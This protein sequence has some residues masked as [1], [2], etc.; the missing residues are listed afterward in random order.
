MSNYFQILSCTSD[1]STCCNDY[2]LVKILSIIKTI[3]VMFQII[4]P[5]LLIVMAVV[6]LIKLVLHPDDK[7]LS[8]GLINK[9]IAALICFILPFIVDLTLSI[10]PDSFQLSGCWK[11]ADQTASTI[12]SNTSTNTKKSGNTKGSTDKVQV[13][14]LIDRDYQTLTLS[15]SSNN[16]SNSGSNNKSSTIKTGSSKGRSIVSYAKSFVGRHYVY[17][18]T[19]N[20]ELPYTGTDCSGFVQGVF[21]HF[22]I[23]LQRS[24]VGQWAD[25]NSYTLVSS[26]NILPGDLVMYELK[27][28]YRHVAIL[29]GNGNEIVHAAS[30]KDGIK[31][32]STYNYRP[33]KG[34]MRIKGVN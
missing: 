2:V 13:V 30:T 1:L 4:V 18:G 12:K 27:D 15:N 29:T 31:L 34:I 6:Q 8:K 14:T 25:T 7:K 23:N 19:W 22:G 24:T 17:G 33:I 21:R 3:L 5:I 28:G 32:S 10:L 9:F 16:K 11:L 26:G 20:G